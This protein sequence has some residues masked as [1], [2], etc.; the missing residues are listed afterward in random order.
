MTDPAPRN[1]HATPETRGLP[2][3]R[4]LDET[5]SGLGGWLILVG[6]GIVLG[7]IILIWQ[8]VMVFSA[9]LGDGVLF[10]FANPGSEFHNPL[11]AAV[12]AFEMIANVAM[13]GLTIYQAMLFFGK[14]RKFPGF[15]IGMQLAYIAL[16]LVDATLVSLA[17]PEIPVFDAE[18][19]SLLVRAI[20]PAMIWIPYMLVSKRVKQ[21][22]VEPVS[23]RPD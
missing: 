23:S 6:I 9:A 15:F 10:A 12:I 19:S 21:T 7:P 16:V 11:G 1:E 13:V 18:T 5:Y 3:Y 22:F 17:F 20:V 8:G 4:A 2:P 14:K